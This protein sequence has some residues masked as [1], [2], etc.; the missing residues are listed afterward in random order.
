LSPGGEEAFS[1]GETIETPY[2]EGV[3]Q[4]TSRESVTVFIRGQGSHKF[5][6]S[7][8]RDDGPQPS[9][10]TQN[11]ALSKARSPSAQAPTTSQS[12]TGG[13]Q[14]PAPETAPSPKPITS[15][16]PAPR[17]EPVSRADDEAD[18]RDQAR[19]RAAVESL[20]LG[21]VPSFAVREATVSR[22]SQVERI[23]SVISSV[24]DRGEGGVLLFTG[25]N[26][27]GKTHL[28]RLTEQMATDARFLVARSDL[29]GATKLT[30]KDV[31]REAVRNLRW[32]S[33]DGRIDGTLRRFLSDHE[34][35]LTQLDLAPLTDSRVLYYLLRRIQTGQQ[36][37]PEVWDYI[38]GDE[39]YAEDLEHTRFKTTWLAFWGTAGQSLGNALN[40]LAYLSR[41]LG[42][43]GF[44]LVLDETELLLNQDVDWAVRGREWLRGLVLSV[45]GGSFQ[46]A[47]G[48]HFEEWET[49]PYRNWQSWPGRNIRK[50]RQEWS[51]RYGG[52]DPSRP[53]H[54]RSD[55]L[56]YAPCGEVP[57]L[58]ALGYTDQPDSEATVFDEVDGFE[59]SWLPT[60]AVDQGIFE[61]EPPRAEDV[62]DLIRQMS[63]L[64]IDAY[65]DSEKNVTKALSTLE[66]D[67][68]GL[69][70]ARLRTGAA[71]SIRWATQT[72]I[73]TFDRAATGIEAAEIRRSLTG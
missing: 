24:R 16:L 59:N 48:E 1:I 47:N 30:P 18:G 46:G 32:W 54:S 42:Y 64:Y 53:P 19:R 35:D 51:L 68:A 27:A 17:L 34:E 60:R 73:E 7:D 40:G 49:R 66:G 44:S 36:I 57:F 3:V 9:G 5:A 56:P 2:G 12:E 11:P 29:E 45:Y 26:G 33:S 14:T 28:L 55:P 65:P 58:L 20:R 8:L 25:P 4:S 31:Y 39:R 70:Q 43:A 72:V 13:G 6:K 38:H 21:T 67:L 37:A 71:S 63:R 23:E 69:I 22:G 52:V 10:T 61:M 41:A 50:S 62:I 15:D